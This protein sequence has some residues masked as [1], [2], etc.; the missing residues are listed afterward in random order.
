M[1]I[2]CVMVAACA[3]IVGVPTLGIGFL[4][5][6]EYAAVGGILLILAAAAAATSVLLEIL[7]QVTRLAATARDI[8]L[9]EIASRTRRVD[10]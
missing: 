2:F 4:I 8:E 9:R 1:R 3:I 7:G 10:G 6:P 5:S